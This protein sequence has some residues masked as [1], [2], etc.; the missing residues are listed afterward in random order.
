[1]RPEQQTPR[2]TLNKGRYSVGRVVGYAVLMVGM[3]DSELCFVNTS[4]RRRRLGQ[5]RNSRMP[6]RTVRCRH[7][8]WT[9]EPVRLLSACFIVYDLLLR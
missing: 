7:R 3:L 5:A 9:V 2:C 8:R 6:W 4:C 1:M